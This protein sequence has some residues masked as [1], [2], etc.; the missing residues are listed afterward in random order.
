MNAVFITKK[1]YGG[2]IIYPKEVPF[3]RG[4]SAVRGDMFPYGKVIYTTVFNMIIEDKSIN[5]I[6]KQFTEM[7]EKLETGQ[8]SNDMLTVSKMLGHSLCAPKCSDERL[9]EVPPLHW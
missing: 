4:V 3:F 6:A 9:C 8:V 2:K 7:I 1:R 5:T